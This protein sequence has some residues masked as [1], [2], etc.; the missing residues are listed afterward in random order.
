M[1]KIIILFVGVVFCFFAHA[2][3]CQN[4][5]S[6]QFDKTW[7]EYYASA[8]AKDAKF[9]EAYFNFPL[10]LKG[11]YDDEKPTMISK[12]FFFKNYSFIFIKNKVTESTEF[13]KEFKKWK[14]EKLSPN[15]FSIMERFCSGD[16]IGNVDVRMGD[17][18]FRWFPKKGWKI[19]EIFY[20]TEDKDNLSYSVNN[21]DVEYAFP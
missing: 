21:P 4:K 19:T 2:S 7:S 11:I 1:K 17:V 5:M 13:Y 6:A 12:N 15:S 9:L 14:K 8:L 10:K 18:I 16:Y 20:L 3:D